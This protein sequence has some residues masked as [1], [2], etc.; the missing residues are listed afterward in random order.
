MKSQVE[1]ARTNV[2]T[3]SRT[4]QQMHA[5]EPLLMQQNQQSHSKEPSG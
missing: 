3:H 1:D 5:H 2:H 4:S